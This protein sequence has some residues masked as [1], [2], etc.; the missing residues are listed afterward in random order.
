MGAA[1]RRLGRSLFLTRPPAASRA[2]DGADGAHGGDE[3]S[4]TSESDT[5][6]VGGIFDAQWLP[7]SAD[8]GELNML[9]LLNKEA[10]ADM[11]RPWIRP[12]KKAFAAYSSIADGLTQTSFA[13]VYDARH[14]MNLT[15]LQRF[16]KEFNLM[17]ACVAPP[18]PSPACAA[19]MTACSRGGLRAQLRE[20][21]GGAAPVLAGHHSRRCAAAGQ[22]RL[23]GAGAGQEP[24]ANDIRRRE[25]VAARRPD[26][27][28]SFVAGATRA[29]H[30]FLAHVIAGTPRPPHSS[31]RS[32]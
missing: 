17:P 20:P 13:A 27:L 30:Y 16:L 22:R 5:E 9:E 21:R 8:R 7:S 19:R 4:A 25:F 6:G 31:A 32:C 3:S 10:A 29:P 2:V 12:L 14:S 15:E 23:A 18:A 26:P 1:A 24:G 11:F 28:T